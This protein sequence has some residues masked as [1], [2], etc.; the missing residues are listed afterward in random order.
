MTPWNQK[1]KAIKSSKS[2]TCHQMS[3]LCLKNSANT[4]ILNRIDNGLMTVSSRHNKL[5]LCGVSSSGWFPLR[6][7][8]A[9]YSLLAWFVANPGFV[10]WKM[11]RSSVSATRG[12]SFPTP[13]T[14]SAPAKQKSK[15][16]TVLPRSLSQYGHT[17]SKSA[18]MHV[19]AHC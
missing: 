1:V 18:P 9:Y 14:V 2:E 5:F 12:K 6:T 16:S 15:S 19:F 11:L 17:S 3:L 8:T 7:S 10:H 13:T 4:F